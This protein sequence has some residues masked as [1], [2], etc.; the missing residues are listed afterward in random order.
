MSPFLSRSLGSVLI[1]FLL[2][3]LVYLKTLAPGLTFGDGGELIAAAYHLGIPHAP[4]FPLWVILTHLFTLLPGPNIA[5]KVNLA[6]AFY[7]SLTAAAIYVLLK[8]RLTWHAALAAALTF[9]FF[10]SSWFYASYAEVLTLTGLFTALLVILLMS[11]EKKGQE[12]YL[13]ALIF[14]AG[15]SLTV[16]YLSLVLFPAGFF[17]LLYREGRSLFR[18]RRLVV[19]TVVFLISLTPFL[20]MPWRSQRG[21]AIDWGQT[22]QSGEN[23]FNHLRR[24]QFGV[25]AEA[26]WGIYLPATLPGGSEV[27]IF[28]RLFSTQTTLL[29]NLNRQFTPPLLLLGVLGWLR[30]WRRERSLFVFLSLG[31]FFAGPV[32]YFVSGPPFDAKRFDLGELVPFLVLFSLALG[33][34]WQFLWEKA[35]KAYPKWRLTIPFL[36]FCFPIFF[37]L[38][39]FSYVN[40][41]QDLT[42]VYHGQNL[43]KT[44]APGSV[45]VTKENNWFF[46][47]VY[48]LRVEGQRGDLTVYDYN[49]NLLGDYFR[50]GKDVNDRAATDRA[51]SQ[52]VRD[53]I[54]TDRRP[55]YFAVDKPF[56]NYGYEVNREGIL[57]KGKNFPAREVDFYE[58]YRNI[59]DLP[60]DQT[61]D[62]DGQYVKA[63]YH[64]EY[65]NDLLKKGQRDLSRD[66]SREK[67]LAEYEKA[68]QM[69]PW[70][71][72]IWN[73]VATQL[74]NIKEFSLAEKYY[75][76]LLELD[77]NNQIYFFNLATVYDEAGYSAAAEELYQKSLA[78][79]AEVKT[80]LALADLYE[81]R[82]DWQRALQGYRRALQMAPGNGSVRQK[83]KEL[84][85]KVRN[86][87]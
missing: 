8:T 23:F 26:N 6:S 42:A 69:A 73:N 76:K 86:S 13:A 52:K 67:A 18:P 75:K 3:F 27:S 25:V 30:L 57:Y 55:V 39:N 68:T 53:L 58:T 28:E 37:L 71:P 29:R 66:S 34:G 43:L 9:A 10:Y 70:S 84:E 62:F 44:V 59:L 20:F 85:G 41:S 64:L 4:G 72:I 31:L 24:K 65:G 12:R 80:V 14:V 33:F 32:N 47:L 19:L 49:A 17:Y 74:A 45:L 87:N 21:V 16:H 48:F 51:R 11:W 60:T 1:S 83:V 35:A 78:V 79:K 2:P 7:G 22:G 54:A 50:V 61:G 82:A 38:K 81:R 40:L 56:E 77:Q 46:P 5:W 15:L 36:A 63:Y